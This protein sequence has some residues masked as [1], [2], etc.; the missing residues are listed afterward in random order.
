MS[1]AHDLWR[2]AP[3]VEGD[4]ATRRHWIIVQEPGCVPEKKGGFTFDQVSPFLRELM[5][6]RPEK[7]QLT[8]VSLTWDFDIWVESGHDW[9]RTD[10]VYAALAADEDCPS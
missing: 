6:C 10:E 8:V 4:L 3:K 7:T 2:Y 9:L 5:A 1:A